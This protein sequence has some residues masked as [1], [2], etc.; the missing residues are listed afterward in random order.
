M[1]GLNWLKVVSGLWNILILFPPLA[2]LPLTPAPVALFGT[3]MLYMAE[4]P[5]VHLAPRTA[6]SSVVLFWP[7]PN[8]STLPLR[9]LTNSGAPLRTVKIGAIRHPPSRC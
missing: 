9:L 2:R 8:D 3:L 6:P 5:P 1:Q 4:V 7:S